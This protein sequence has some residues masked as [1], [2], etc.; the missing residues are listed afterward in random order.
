MGIELTGRWMQEWHMQDIDAINM[1]IYQ[2]VQAL[3][4]ALIDE[5]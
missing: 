1:L 3:P 2:I 5:T 4:H